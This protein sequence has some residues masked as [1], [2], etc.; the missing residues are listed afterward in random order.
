MGEEAK[1]ML[2]SLNDLDFVNKNISDY[3]A[4]L[5]CNEQC[6]RVEEKKLGKTHL[7]KQS[8]YPSS[9]HLLN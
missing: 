3:Q 9:W 4:A 8:T 5:D 7:Y 1:D 2:G 6:Q